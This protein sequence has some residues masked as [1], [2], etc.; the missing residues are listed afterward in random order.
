MTSKYF[1]SSY[2]ESKRLQAIFEESNDLAWL[3]LCFSSTGSDK[4]AEVIG[5]VFVCNTVKLLDNS[6]LERY[7]PNLPPITESYGNADAVCTNI[8][9]INWELEWLS[10]KCVL[11]KKEGAPWALIC[12]DDKRGMCKAIRKSGPWGMEWSVGKYKKM[13]LM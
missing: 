6:E 9:E 11:L 2:N 7:K 4:P 13:T 12:P 5:D 1:L 10:D 8:S 3:Y